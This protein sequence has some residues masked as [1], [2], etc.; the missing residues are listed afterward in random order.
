MSGTNFFDTPP[1]EV[2]EE[3]GDAYREAYLKAYAEAQAEFPGEIPPLGELHDSAELSAMGLEPADEPAD[4]PADEPPSHEPAA[5]GPDDEPTQGMPLGTHRAPSVERAA[6]SFETFRASAWFIPALI[7]VAALV[8]ILVAY[9]LGRVLGG[10][11]AATKTPTVSATTPAPTKGAAKPKPLKTQTAKPIAN[12][13]AGDVTPTTIASATA[14]CTAPPGVD[15]SGKKVTYG[16]GHA[17]DDQTDTAWRCDGSAVGQKIVLDLGRS[18]PIGEVGLVP[19]YAK[20]DSES[21]V[22][23]YAQNNRITKVRWT[24]DDGSSVV[25]NLSGN[26]QDRSLQAVRVPKTDSAT[27]TL[28]IL[29][30]TN[31]PRNTTAISDVQFSVAN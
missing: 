27:V 14:T 7:A 13:Y 24:F 12:A 6:P 8:L 29:A 23:R 11:D 5:E 22:D 18:Q 3:F 2:P 19:G 9:V 17:I 15:S 28:Q 31:G 4:Q 16:V 1:P 30:V 26:P 20:T 10:D 21:H 25:Q